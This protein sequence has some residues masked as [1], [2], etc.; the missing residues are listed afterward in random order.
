[1]ARWLQQVNARR[2]N[3]EV[4]SKAGIMAAVER[5][6]EWNVAVLFCAVVPPSIK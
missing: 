5:G 6:M 4:S 2:A 1:M 3:A